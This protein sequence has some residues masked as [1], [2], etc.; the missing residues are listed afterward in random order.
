MSD[1]IVKS[2]LIAFAAA[3]GAGAWQMVDRKI[4]QM[5]KMDKIMKKLEEVEA[6]IDELTTEEVEE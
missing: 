1:G 6:K 2:G 3:A 5:D 4:K